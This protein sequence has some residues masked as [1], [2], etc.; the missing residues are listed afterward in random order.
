MR[1]VP[2][3]RSKLGHVKG[4]NRTKNL[5]ILEE[6]MNSGHDCMKLE[7][8]THARAAGCQSALQQSAKR[9]GLASSIAIVVRNDE[10]FLIRRDHE[11]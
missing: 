1:L 10:V 2:Y 5:E 7:N 4:Y 9:Y 3:D 8:F 11:E 6:F